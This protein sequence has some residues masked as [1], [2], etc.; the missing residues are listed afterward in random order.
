MAQILTASDT[1]KE[2]GNYFSVTKEVPQTF[3]L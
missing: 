2:K 3:S 1:M